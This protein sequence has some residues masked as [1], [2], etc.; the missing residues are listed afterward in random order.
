MRILIADDEPGTRTV[1]RR[2]LMRHFPCEVGEVDNGMDALQRLGAAPHALLLLDV[3][4][5]VLNGIETLR[6]IRGHA[7]TSAL[8]VVM[9]TGSTDEQ[10][11]RE[12]VALGVSDYVIKPVR[13][14]V[15]VERVARLTAGSP[16]GLELPS[17]A[18]HSRAQAEPVRIHPGSR[19]LLV[20]GNPDFRQLFRDV[21]GEQAQLSEAV[22]GIEALRLFLTQP[23]DS[24][25]VGSDIGLLGT[26]GLARQLRQTQHGHRPALV[27]V[28]PP[29]AAAK[30]RDRDLFDGMIQRT[31][32]ASR[33]QAA[34]ADL[35][36]EVDES[37]QPALSA[38]PNLRLMLLSAAEQTLAQ[39]LG[40]AMSVRNAP[41][42]LFAQGMEASGRVTL[43]HAAVPGLRVT[44][45]ASQRSAALLTDRLRQVDSAGV[46]P[47][48]TGVG[49]VGVTSL[50]AGRLAQ[51]LTEA[52]MGAV[53][54]SEIAVQPP[55]LATALS[56]QFLR[57][58]VQT[59]P[60]G[61]TLR[62][63]VTA[64]SPVEPL[65]A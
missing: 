44:V 9:M 49:L 48:E 65:A 31:F 26:D 15:I 57:I 59:R 53:L 52:G 19:V 29:G 40:T 61:L 47:E 21:V 63:T 20:D 54:D 3:K 39:A 6:A 28:L 33:L 36:S 34:I 45:M 12:V 22:T 7:S 10:I 50:L 13:P 43:S 46:V 64:D 23:Q 2:I 1:V 25:F 30:R 56:G 8:P 51:R 18:R 24:V 4:M 37:T 5:P 62:I 14:A 60:A 11:V 42:V 38:I 27:R 35:G 41:P 58:L 32:T 17:D 16:T 55:G